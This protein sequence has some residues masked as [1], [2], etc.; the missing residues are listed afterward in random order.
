MSTSRTELSERAKRNLER[1]AELRN[2][3]NKYLSI[4]PGAKMD[5]L[6]DPERIEVVGQYFWDGR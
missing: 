2:I 4:P 5:L 1:N 6:F 3:D